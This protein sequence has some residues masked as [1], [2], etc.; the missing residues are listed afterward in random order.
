MILRDQLIQAI[1][2]IIG[3]KLLV[4][5]LEKDELANGVQVLGQEKINKVALGVSLNEEFLQKAI[6]W[7][8]QFCLFHHGFDPR[9]YKSRLPLYSQ[10]RLKLI[11]QNNLTVMGFHYCL[12]AHPKI[13]NNAV[14]IKKLGAKIKE[15]FWDEWG[16][17]AEFLQPQDV[18][19]LAEK[20]RQIFNH[21]IFSLLSGSKKVKT[22]GVV[23]GAAKPYAQELTEMEAKGVEL[24]ITG[25]TSESIPHKMK[26]SG[27][28]YFAGGHY[29]TE[30]FGIQALGAKIKEKFTK[31]LE[32][33]FI[34]IRNPI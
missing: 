4:K 28:N 6:L 13:G 18:V 14:I 15:P 16:Y 30:V 20:C 31:T 19:K 32:V 24:F 12:D 9:T 34:D 23:S 33:K 10:K 7:G 25:E 29:A 17:T 5:A 27:I 1:K 11:F 21:E 22:I 26:E 8:A 2:Q 3:R